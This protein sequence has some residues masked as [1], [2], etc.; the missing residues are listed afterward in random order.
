MSPSETAIKALTALR[1]AIKI[2]E[3][4]LSYRR[5]GRHDPFHL[6]RLTDLDRC[7]TDANGAVWRARWGNRAQ[8][9]RE[10]NCAW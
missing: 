3:L 1:K 2:F 9:R 10:K 4:A 7:L 5:F 8:Y 6:G